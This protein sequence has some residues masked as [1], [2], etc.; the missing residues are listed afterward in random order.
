LAVIQFFKLADL[1]SDFRQ[2]IHRH[3]NSFGR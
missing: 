3:R 2:P 1:L